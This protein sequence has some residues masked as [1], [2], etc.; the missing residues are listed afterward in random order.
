MGQ[1][2]GRA[3]NAASYAYSDLCHADYDLGAAANVLS[4]AGLVAWSKEADDLM[5]KCI[6]LRERIH[7]EA[8]L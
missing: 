4:G 5:R 7:K 3:R 2:G 1:L 6:E 8:G